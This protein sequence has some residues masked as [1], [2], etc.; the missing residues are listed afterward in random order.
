[1]KTLNTS[2]TAAGVTG[3]ILLTPGEAANYVVA[4]T[5][6]GIVRL[7]R[8]TKGDA[9]EVL[10]T[11]AA[12]TGFTGSV[13]NESQK[14][15][16]Y[17]FRIDDEV[18]LADPAVVVTGTA[19]IL[20]IQSSSDAALAAGAAAGA[21]VT[22]SETVVGNLHTTVLTCVAADLGAFGDEAGQGQFAGVKVYDFPAGL[23]MPMGEVVAGSV[24]LSAPAIDAWTGAIG[25]G[26][27]VP[28]DKQDAANLA[29]AVMP[30]VAISAATAKVGAVDAVTVA[31]AKT[32]S[33]ARWLDGTAAA[34]DLCLNL[35][36]ADN[37][38]HDNTITGTFTGTITF[39]WMNLGDN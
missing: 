10:H 35:L 24:T 36:V 30:T 37:V 13:K 14:N 11:G 16:R 7:E 33:G 15:A 20:L 9:W 5:F 26:V 29:G 25:L 4:G 34:K 22:A 32:E 19:T 31:A 1:M 21:N 12:D 39:T 23:I 17:R 18:P 2:L 38:A 27:T 8:S 3:I 6:A 28:L